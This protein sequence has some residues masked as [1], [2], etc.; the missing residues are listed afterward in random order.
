MALPVCETFLKLGGSG[1]LYPCRPIRVEGL[2][3]GLDC[4][5]VVRIDNRNRLP[6]AVARDLV[7]TVR[8]TNLRGVN[9]RWTCRLKGDEA[10]ERM[11]HD[12]RRMINGRRLAA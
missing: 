10:A 12:K 1:K 8:M 5:R 3:I 6:R 4:R 2:Q 9:A 7:E 11:K